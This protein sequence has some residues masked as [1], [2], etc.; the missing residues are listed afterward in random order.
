MAKD[1]RSWIE[2]L[3]EAG[4]LVRI[5]DEVDPKLNMSGY[6]Y[7]S[8]E[9]ALLFE[10]VKNHSG[11]E[12]LGQ[13]PANMRHVGLAFGTKAKQAITEFARRMDNGL[14]DCTMVNRGPVKEV[15]LKDKDVHLTSL[16][17]HIQGHRDAGPYITAGL[18]IVKDPETGVRNMAFHRLQVKGDNKLGIMM[19]PGRH[20]HII[21]Q[22]YEAMDK[23]MPIAIMIGHHPMYYLSACYT[24]P[25]ELDELAIA[26]ALLGEAVELIKC[27]TID[28]E[29]PAH[30]E[31]I[32]EGEI[33]PKVRE[34]EGPFSEF[35][36][37]YF[38]GKGKNPIINIKAMT[39]RGDAIFK[40][41]QNG[42]DTEGCI[43]HRVPMSAALFRDLRHVGGYV[44]LKDVYAHWGTIFGV[45][46]QMTPRF[47]GEAKNVLLASMSSTYLHQKFAIAVDEDVD[48]Y[49]PADVAW[50][51]TTR[52][53]PVKDIIIIPGLRGHALDESVTEKLREPQVTIRQEIASKVMIDATRP[54]TSDPER[55]AVYE[56]LKP[57]GLE[58]IGKPSSGFIG[59]TDT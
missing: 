2:Q 35:Q 15:I 17:A 6:L 8:K 5:R 57:L 59:K 31:I 19:I 16:P 38:G 45:V 43:Y 12:V 27:E 21:Y 58:T 28:L 11:W 40:A 46:I 14:I 33:P 54:P 51:I 24:G 4:E 10:N 42:P 44:D 23:P 48:I 34:E 29:A 32:L 9:K 18:C 22:K 56:R 7:Q 55:R 1:M 50:A 37:Y 36:G 47:Y 26:G 20:T 53:D 52:V 25:L 3:E 49:D 39:K 30:G 41:N 13:A